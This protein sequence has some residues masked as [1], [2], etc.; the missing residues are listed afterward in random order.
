MSQKTIVVKSLPSGYLVITNNLLETHH[1]STESFILKNILFRVFDG[2]RFSATFCDFP[3][4]IL[5]KL[6]LPFFEENW[7]I[8]DN[9]S[10]KKKIKTINFEPSYS[11]LKRSKFETNEIFKNTNVTNY[12]KKHFSH[13]LCSK[14]EPWSPLLR[15]SYKFYN[16]RV[17]FKNNSILINFPVEQTVLSV[18]LALNYFFFIDYCKIYPSNIFLNSFKNKIDVTN[19]FEYEI[20][21]LILEDGSAHFQF[22]LIF[23]NLNVSSV[24]WELIFYPEF[25]NKEPKFYF[26]KELSR[27]LIKNED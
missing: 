20:F 5:K 9:N 14:P 8:L 21:R 4:P 3:N 13:I 18:N 10:F 7:Y 1:L 16:S 26:Y 19:K 25:R 17:F 23:D 11:F 22:E 6:H 15:N 2:P 27:W 24:F 12:Y